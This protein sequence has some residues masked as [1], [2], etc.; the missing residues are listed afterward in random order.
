MNEYEL[1][2]VIDFAE[3]TRAPFRETMPVVDDDPAWQ[4]TIH[5]IRSE[6][7]GELVTISSLAQ[8]AGVPYATARRMIRRM[9][10]SEAII[11]RIRGQTGKSHSLHPSKAL[12]AAFEAYARS[13]KRL[14]AQTVGQRPASDDEG[15]Y[16]FG[17]APS[18]QGDVPRGPEAMRGEEAPIRFLCSNDNY[19][20]ALRNMW[21]DLRANFASTR[22]FDLRPL[23]DLYDEVRANA[24]RPESRYD[25]I[26]VN[27]PWLAQCAADGL[28][29]PLDEIIQEQGLSF[30]HFHPA[31]RNRSICN[32]A[33]YGVPIY[34]TIAIL[35]ARRDWFE[36]ASLAFPRSFDDVILAARR[37]HQPERGRFGVVWDGARGMP[38]AS[39]FLF[40]L[41]AC[42]GA[43]GEG[44]DEIAS[45]ARRIGMHGATALDFMHRLLDVAPPDVLSRAWDSNLAL[46]IEG[47]ASL[48]YCWTM[49]A[50]RM[51]YDIHSIVKRR[52][53][54]LPQPSGPKGLRASPI[55][56]F[57]LAIPANLP[58]ER[59][60]VAMRAIG[61]MAS[62]KSMQA[63]VRNGF[64]IAPRFLT[65][66]EP[67]TAAGSP[68]VRFVDTLAHRK[69]LST[70]QRPHVPEYR[71]IE[72]EIGGVI[73]A[74]M[75]REMSDSGA[76]LAIRDRLDALMR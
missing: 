8:V 14:I 33:T 7:R 63:H 38:I 37:F 46:F 9:I 67:G 16:Y 23:P 39:S 68:I 71:A 72:S 58:A 24:T 55:G 74:A 1:L 44:E 53:E 56:G 35:A 11:R 5:L 2:R 49:R 42:G 76:L 4:I 20:L 52:V 45:L 65:R 15:D 31:I 26:T 40:F 43:P 61:W 54:Y 62:D 3:R 13:I 27:M 36:E 21:S 60:K 32:G 48:A 59:V 75:T 10:E 70:W 73:H 30:D 17:G 47:R 12:I 6:V 28:V 25:I 64:P 41:G 34:S 66:A 18:G 50:A 22:D 69:L 51:E 19:F 57:M 29:M